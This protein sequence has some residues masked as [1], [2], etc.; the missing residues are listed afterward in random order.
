MD[1]ICSLM[2][3]TIKHKAGDKGLPPYLTNAALFDDNFPCDIQTSARSSL[4]GV[5]RVVASSRIDR[6]HFVVAD[7]HVWAKKACAKLQ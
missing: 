5:S 4:D 7:I 6:K 2:D 3:T 1:Q